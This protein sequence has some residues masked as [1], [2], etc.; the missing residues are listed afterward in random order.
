[1]IGDDCLAFAQMKP[2][3]KNA[4]KR[5]VEGERAAFKDDRRLEFQSLGQ[6]ADGLFGD[7]V[8]T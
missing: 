3:L 6:S 1:M 5:G 8:K 2:L 4:A 7:G